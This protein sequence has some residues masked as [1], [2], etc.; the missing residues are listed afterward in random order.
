MLPI[1]DAQK[2]LLEN[3][4][5][6]KKTEIIPIEIAN[7]RVLAIDIQATFDMPRFDNSAM[8]G[9][10]IKM[11]DIGKK[12]KLISK[13]LAGDKNHSIKEGECIKIMTGAKV[14]KSI[15]AVV[16]VEFVEVDGDIIS[17]PNDVKKSANIRPQGEEFKKDDILLQKGEILNPSKIALIASLGIT[18]IK[19][20]QK[21]KVLIIPTG[22]EIKNH[23]ETINEVEHFNSS[24]IYF[25]LESLADVSILDVVGDDINIIKENI[26]ETYDLII[27]T[28]G[29]SKGDADFTTEA[30]RQKGYDIKFSWIA[31]KPGKP[32]GF[33]VG[34][35]IACLLTGNPLAAVFNYNIFVKPLIRKL[36]GC[37]DYYLDYIELFTT[38]SLQRKAGRDE[39]I[40]VNLTSD[41]VELSSKRGSGMIS[42]TSK[43]DG[44]IVID[45]S[46]WEIKENDKV[47]FI[48]FN[49]WNE[50]FK[51]F[52]SE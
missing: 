41:G 48:D 25:K 43:S 17:I 9:Y 15:E 34:K 2:I 22:N 33:A 31:I 46:I 10:G 24:S 52:I 6:I 51:E 19:V 26:D 45:K 11:A 49:R 3:T 30:F 18:H 14:D 12:V 50:K 16:P 5:P 28:G 36:A 7:N 35:N 27:T 8:D 39:V 40:P 23:Y 44:V 32:F 47:K 13:T 4:K 38:N 42:V 21:P 29:V 37:K 20:F 1:Y